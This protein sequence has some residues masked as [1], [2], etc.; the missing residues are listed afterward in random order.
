MH[1]NT[2]FW[3]MSLTSSRTAARKSHT[4][5]KSHNSPKSPRNSAVEQTFEQTLQRMPSEGVASLTPSQR[6]AL[7]T[8]IPG[9]QSS[10]HALDLRLTIPFPGRGFY[11]VLFGGR[12]RRSIKRLRENPNYY[13]TLLGSLVL[14]ALLAGVTVPGILWLMRANSESQQSEI[15]PTAIPWLQDQKACEETG[16]IWQEDSCL[17]HEWS[18][19]Y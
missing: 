8:V 1:T 6:E 7:R 10:K 11:L 14:L 19:T 4:S 18:H 9:G 12:E 2:R 17:E 13:S 3:L 5:P 16:R 15:H